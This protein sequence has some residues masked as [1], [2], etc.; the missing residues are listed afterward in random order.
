MLI[1]MDVFM[2]NLW[3][4]IAGVM[5]SIAMCFFVVD[6]FGK[7]R[8][9]SDS[10]SFGLLNSVAVVMIVCM[11]WDYKINKNGLSTR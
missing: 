6:R 11:Q 3:F 1:Y 4:G 5:V 9:Y 2:N 7:M 8:L 10:E